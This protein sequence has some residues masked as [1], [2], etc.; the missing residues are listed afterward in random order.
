MQ[1]LAESWHKFA[2]VAVLAASWSIYWSVTQSQSQEARTEASMRQMR[3]GPQGAKAREE[4]AARSHRDANLHIAGWAGVALVSFF[5]FL[6]DILKAARALAGGEGQERKAGLA[7]L[8]LAAACG[9]GGCGYRPF[10]PVKL[11]TIKS[12][13]EAF[14]IPLGADGK[15]QEASD[16][17]E[18]LKS[19]LVYGKQ[20][21][22]PQQWRPKGY[23][24]WGANG[25]WLDAAVL[26]RVDTSPV[27]REWTA[28]PASGTS[29]KNE[30]VWVMTSDQVEFSTG[31]TITARIE[32]REDAVR[33]LHNY[34]NGSLA[35]VLD[36]E[37][38]SKLQAE[39]G[40]AVT[41]LP[42]EKL[43]LAATP[44]ITKVVKNVTDFFKP[45][46]ITITNLGIS[47]GFVYKDPAIIAMM[48]RVF[49]AEQEQAIAKAATAAQSERNKANLSKAQGDAD[50]IL[51]TKKAEADGI[52]M[53]AEARAHELEKAKQDVAAYMA[54]K[55]LEL[56][57]ELL[58]KWDGSY[59]RYFMG[60]GGA[61]TPN[62]LLQL[63]AVDAGTRPAGAEKGKK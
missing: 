63:P 42:M 33:F 41:D 54:I 8:A 47:G 52:K 58:L 38:R 1:Y 15:K 3:D 40:L 59:P 57:K 61:A 28:D 16:S 4:L 23:E 45:R 26:I 22:I 9:A 56:Q 11:E 32:G 21:Q 14:L 55:Q 60:G 24:T 27:T 5:V 53:V 2:L 51:K 12:N 6:A 50:A 31:W 10:E 36:S 30:A 48:V 29:K 34:P 17:K 35:A 20:V 7:A 49:T 62:M 44:V 19:N 46:G 37:V 18:Y 43:R 39:F 13:E 25:E